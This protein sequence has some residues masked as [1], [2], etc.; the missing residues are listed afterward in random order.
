MSSLERIKIGHGL[1]ILTFILDNVTSH[2]TLHN[3]YVVLN[4][5]VNEKDIKDQTLA[6]DIR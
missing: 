3:H 6:P 5:A 2:L 1:I 4:V